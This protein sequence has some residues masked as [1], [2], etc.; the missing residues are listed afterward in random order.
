MPPFDVLDNRR[1]DI[2][3]C[4]DAPVNVSRRPVQPL[5]LELFHDARI[6]EILR[7]LQCASLLDGADSSANS[8]HEVGGHHD[9]LARL[10]IG[11]MADAEVCG[12]RARLVEIKGKLFANIN[13]HWRPLKQKEIVPLQ[14]AQEMMFSASLPSANACGE[15]LRRHVLHS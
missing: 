13:N 1:I 12:N 14:K 10:R 3:F 7:V 6:G 11:W 2:E 8:V 9:G 15:T 4:D 5:D